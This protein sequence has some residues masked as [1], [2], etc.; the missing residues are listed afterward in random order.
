MRNWFDVDD[1]RSCSVPISKWCLG[2][3]EIGMNKKS[4]TFTSI[5]SS[6]EENDVKNPTHKSLT[7][8][9]KSYL[10]FL[11]LNIPRT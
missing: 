10:T 1:I 11:S 9:N 5:D 8:G 7:Y 3:I 4:A 6:I 2:Y